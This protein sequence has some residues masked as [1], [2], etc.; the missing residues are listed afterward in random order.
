MLMKEH[1][2]EKDAEKLIQG[3]LK[4]LY[5]D[6]YGI[7]DDGAVKVAAFIKVDDTVEAVNL[8]GNYIGSRAAKAI[9]D[10]LKHNKKVWFLNLGGNPIGDE[11]A[12]A[13]IDAL[14]QNVCMTGLYV[15]GNNIARGS[16]A[17]IKY[18][19]GTRNAIQIPAAARRASL[20]LIAARRATPISNAGD[21]AI[22]P[23]EIVRLIAMA[24]WATRKDPKWIEATKPAE[25]QVKPVVPDQGR[26]SVQ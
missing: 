18:L 15:L 12:D 21:F 17:T 23:K 3:E 14:S 9:A 10:A 4:K 8:Y 11:G 6:S 1:G 5:L 19:T 24:V 20:Y 16:V 25:V 2:R 7:G 13:L 26:C 22:F